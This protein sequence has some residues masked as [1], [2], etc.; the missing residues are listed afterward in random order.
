MSEQYQCP[1]CQM[2]YTNSQLFRYIYRCVSCGHYTG[3]DM[4]QLRLKCSCCEY[5]S[6]PELVEIARG[7]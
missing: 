4:A 6:E 3:S 7:E 5:V 1:T 2:V